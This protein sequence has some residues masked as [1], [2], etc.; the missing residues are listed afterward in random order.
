[1]ADGIVNSSQYLVE[2]SGG[3]Q[4]ESLDLNFAYHRNPPFL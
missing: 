1:M 3:G 2:R 4:A